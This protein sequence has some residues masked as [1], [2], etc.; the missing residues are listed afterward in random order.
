MPANDVHL[1]E[2]DRF[3]GCLLG[4]ACGDAVGTT[5]EFRPRGGFEPLTDMVGGG[6]FGLKPGEWTDDTS[7]ALCLAASLTELGRF[8]ARDQMQRYCRWWKEGYMGSNGRCFDIGNTVRAAL[9]RFQQTGEPF[10]GSTEPRSA[11]NGCIM[12]LAPVPMFFYPDR[13]TAVEMSAESSRTTH[14]AAECLDACR[15][16]AAILFAALDRADKESLLSAGVPLEIQ[17]PKIQAIA[18]GEY[19]ERRAEEV[20]GSGYV[21]DCLEAALWCFRRSSRFDEAVLMAANLGDDADTTAA[22]CGQVAGAFYGE[23]GIPGKW[24]E[25]IVMCDE[26]RSLADGLRGSQGVGDVR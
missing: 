7:M 15:L 4:L 11:G 17:S 19:R 23:S 13:R 10:S 1:H 22:V 5:V 3:R 8:D 26:I 25:R 21:V 9:G 24:L 12:R 18:R 14:A 20:R 2:R 6:P 16:L